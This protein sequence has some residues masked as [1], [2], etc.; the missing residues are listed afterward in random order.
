MRLI[1]PGAADGR[2]AGTRG[3][4]AG[5]RWASSRMTVDTAIVDGTAGAGGQTA[6]CPHPIP[7]RHRTLALRLGRLVVI[8]PIC[9]AGGSCAR[10]MFR[11]E[12]KVG[13]SR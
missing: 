6:S 1:T 5:A 13:A 4:A 7:S 11:I 12:S 8:G 9:A 2:G 3:A 10:L